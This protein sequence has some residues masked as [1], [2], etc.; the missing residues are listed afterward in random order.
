M[1]KKLDIEN[2]PQVGYCVSENLRDEQ[3][4][5]NIQKVKGRIQSVEESTDEPIAIVCFGSSL[6][7]TW[8]QVKG[9]KKIMTCSGAHKFLIDRG[10][11]PT[12]H[13]ELEP[14]EH[15]IK[16]LGEPHKETEYLIAS[17]VHPRYIDALDGYNVKLWH[18]FAT[19]EG[20]MV[21]PRG[22]WLITG[23]SSVGLRCITLARFMGY[24]NLHI[25]GMDGSFGESGTHA[26]EHP[27]APK[28]FSD[29]EYNGKIYKTTPS[30]AFCAKETWKELD[31]MPD[32]KATFYGE[33]L[34]Q[35]MAKDYVPNPI[36]TALIAFNKPELISP[37]YIQLNKKLHEDNPM[38]GMGGSKHADTILK[39][40]KELK[41]TDILDYGAGKMMLQKSLPFPIFN[42]D[43]CV[44]EISAT[45]R[46]ADILVCTDVLEHIENDKL[47]FVLDDIRRCMKKVGYLVISTRKAV[48]TY[49]NGSNTHSIVQGKDWWQKK[50]SKF[51][52]IGTI[53]DKPEVSE[54]HVVIAPKTKKEDKNVTV[55]KVGETKMKFYTPNDTTK[56]R[57]DT[58]AT[59]EPVTIDWIKGMKP[60]SVLYDVGANVGSYTVFAGVNGHKVY[61]FEPE[62]ENHATLVRNMEINGIEA[63][64]YCVAMSDNSGIGELYVNGGG[65]GQACHAFGENLTPELKEANP[66]HKQGVL[67]VTLDEMVK[68]GLP[69]PDYLKIDVDGLEYN[70]IKG[71]DYVLKNGLTSLLVEVN[72]EIPEHKKMIDHLCSLGYEYDEAQVE[73]AKRKEGTF[74]GVAEY[75]FTKNNKAKEE[76]SP[77]PYIYKENV[78]SDEMYN[79]IKKYL[80]EATYTEIEKSRG[81]RGYPLRYTA[82]PPD[83]V[84]N[85]LMDGSFKKSMLA[86]FNIPEGDYTEDLLL[87]RDLPGYQIPPH[88]DS[89]KKVVTALFYLAEDSSMEDEG[90]T[91]FI[92]KKKGFTCKKGIHH[93]FEDFDKYKTMP[94]KPNTMFAFARTDDSFHGVFPSK[95]IRNVLLYNVNKK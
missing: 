63:N 51:F 93:R 71:G 56:W 85:H 95:H 69:A 65:A 58:I 23:G 59:K 66:R 91:V 5:I 39:L 34:V 4:K 78:F 2:L 48:K 14:R 94:F 41:T 53:I 83:F 50:L 31:Q 29:L 28:S 32:V 18:I 76:G 38:Y 79:D 44:P 6:N 92:P 21:L 15:K 46:P 26:H 35:A 70:V 77:Y 8:E 90:T 16:M 64:A 80:S 17:T 47:N 81:T 24:K 1:I 49:A 75:I 84:T 9:F 12:W 11:I 72:P 60:N 3:I 33:G 68:R 55:V 67:S 22:E 82:P 36:K 37:E 20:G 45:P 87:V 43:P 62:A 13:V 30:I 61:A 52:D 10:V 57:A 25:F 86:Q 19:K 74:K 27:N 7:D 42:Y 89:L 73:K 54:L 40:S 88:T